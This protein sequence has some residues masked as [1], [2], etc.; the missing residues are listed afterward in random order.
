MAKVLIISDSHGLEEELKQI[1]ERHGCKYN[2]HCGDSELDIEEPALDG[3][4]A[5]RGNCDFDARF[6]VEHSV[7]IEGKKVLITH[8]HEQHVNEN[9]MNLAYHAQEEGADIVCFG[10]THVPFAEQNGSQFFINPG[11]LKEPRLVSEKTYAIIDLTHD[12]IDVTFYTL[13]GKPASEL[14]RALIV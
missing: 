10:H 9:I 2:I 13:D 5:V 4:L 6:P 14:N 12:G 1:K 11:S 3:F 8:G 7:M